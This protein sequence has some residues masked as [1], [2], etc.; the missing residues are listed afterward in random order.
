MAAS[1]ATP[2]VPAL[3]AERFFRASLSLLILSSILTL[4]S[5]GKLDIFTIIVAPLAA[6]YKG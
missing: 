1:L 2:R 4:A 5:T 6:L 3:P